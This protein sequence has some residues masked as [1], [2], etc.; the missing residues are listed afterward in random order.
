MAAK[1]A[2]VNELKRT[3]AMLQNDKDNALAMIKRQKT[4]PANVSSAEKSFEFEKARYDR[5]MGSPTDPKYINLLPGD[6]SHAGTDEA[7]YADLLLQDGSSDDDDKRMVQLDVRIKIKDQRMKIMRLQI[8][9]QISPTV[10][11]AQLDKTKPTPFPV[12][13]FVGVY[14]YSNRVATLRNHCGFLD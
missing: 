10:T 9:R 14:I 3:A 13:Q 12:A 11:Q 2:S 1:D 6:I 7:T 4:N 8:A 5:I